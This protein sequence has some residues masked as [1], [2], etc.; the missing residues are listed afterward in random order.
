[1]RRPA[2]ALYAADTTHATEVIVMNVLSHCVLLSAVLRPT[3]GREMITARF[4]VQLTHL[5]S[6]RD[7]DMQHESRGS[8]A[9]AGIFVLLSSV[10][11]HY[12]S[13][14]TVKDTCFTMV[15]P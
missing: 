15:M 6:V 13:N 10:N 11:S 12:S 8:L 9:A 7:Q 14:T 4:T 3:F 5:R 1:M 2:A